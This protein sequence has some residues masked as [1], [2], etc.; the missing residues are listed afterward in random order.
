MANY[1]PGAMDGEYLKSFTDA[2]QEEWFRLCDDPRHY[3]RKIDQA[4]AG[5]PTYNTLPTEALRALFRLILQEQKIV[6]SQEPLT[7]YAHDQGGNRWRLNRHKDV[8]V[9]LVVSGSQRVR[10]QVVI[11]GDVVH[12]TTVEPHQPELILGTF[13]LPLPVLYCHACEVRVIEGSAGDVNIIWGLAN[14]NYHLR[15]LENLIV[16]MDG[17]KMVLV[18]NGMVRSWESKSETD[19][20]VL[21][22]IM[23]C[24]SIKSKIE[25]K[26]KWLGV[27]EE[28]LMRVSWHPCR[29]PWCLDIVD[30]HTIGL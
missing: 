30:R 26:R 25:K 22:P 10:L 4:L 14:S 2:L 3:F 20:Y 13:F 24:E 5:D 29:L 23:M 18:A 17:N 12:E 11:G 28:E 16:P 6:L 27:I 1:L 21:A 9:G 19:G 15:Y 7:D 8:A